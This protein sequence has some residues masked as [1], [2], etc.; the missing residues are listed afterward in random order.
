M[1]DP[2][3]K[4]CKKF[5]LILDVIISHFDR[6]LTLISVSNIV[7]F[8]LKYFQVD[9]LIGLCALPRRMVSLLAGTE[10]HIFVNV[11]LD[12]VVLIAQELLD[13]VQLDIVVVRMV[14]VFRVPACVTVVMQ[15][16]RAR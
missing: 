11:N 14:N 16:R 6:P 9:I 7:H 4:T 10:I 8:T 5:K 1:F 2:V 13:V 15:V 3:K 12:S